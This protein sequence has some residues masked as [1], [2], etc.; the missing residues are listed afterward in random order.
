MAW[1]SGSNGAWLPSAASTVRLPATKAGAVD[2]RQT[3]LGLQRDRR[4]ADHLQR[5]GALHQAA[6]QPR[7]ALADQRQA[8]MGERR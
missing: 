8:E 3:L 6:A 1:M 5:L 7:L 4:Q 2:Q